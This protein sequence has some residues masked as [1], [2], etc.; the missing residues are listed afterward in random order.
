M[1]S[2]TSSLLNG[3]IMSEELFEDDFRINSKVEDISSKKNLNLTESESG[4]N[5]ALN[6]NRRKSSRPTKPPTHLIES[7]TDPNAVGQT[8]HNLI[9]K[10]SADKPPKQIPRSRNNT[11]PRAAP[12]RMTNVYSDFKCDHCGSRYV[13]NPMRRGNKVSTTKYKVAP[14][15]RIDP[16]TRKILSLCNACG[17]RFNRQKKE[18]PVKDVLSE[19]DIQLIKVQDQDFVQDLSTKLGDP[20]ALRLFCP[21][22]SKTACRCIQKFICG[23]GEELSVEAILE[24]ASMLLEVAIKADE[25]KKLKCYNPDETTKSTKV[26]L[27]NGHRKSQEFEDY[28]LAKRQELRNDIK[29]C[30]KGTQKI[31]SYS[32][33]FLHKRMKT[34]P[35]KGFRIERQKGKAAMGA[36]KEIEILPMESCCVDNC[37]RIALTHGRLLQAWRDR[38]SVSQ[39]EAR[40]VLAEMLTPSG[41]NRANCYRFITWVTGCSSTTIGK[42]N[43]QM[44]LTGGDREPP[45]H[46]LKKYW[47]ENPKKKVEQEQEQEIDMLKDFVPSY[48]ILKAA[49][50]SAGIPKIIEGKTE[51]PIP[52]KRKRVKNTNKSTKKSEVKKLS[53]PTVQTNENIQQTNQN[54]N[55]VIALYGNYQNGGGFITLP[56]GLTPSN[57]ITLPEGVSLQTVQQQLQ[58]QHQLQLQIQLL[59]QQLQHTQAALPQGTLHQTQEGAEYMVTVST[60][61]EVNNL[62]QNTPVVVQAVTTQAMLQNVASQTIVP[63]VVLPTGTTGGISFVSSTPEISILQQQECNDSNNTTS[64]RANMSLL[65]TNLTNNEEI[66]LLTQADARGATLLTQQDVED[67]RRALDSTRL[68]HIVRSQPPSMA[69]SQQPVT[70]SLQTPSITL[71]NLP[72]MLL[73]QHNGNEQQSMI[74]QP[75]SNQ[76]RDRILI[77]SLANQVS[78]QDHV[79]LQR[80]VQ[81]SAQSTNEQGVTITTSILPPMTSFN[82]DVFL[83]SNNTA[84]STYSVFNHDP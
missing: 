51:T 4:N 84:G 81:P 37:V 64:Q 17:L 49:A 50:N 70:I 40:R 77:P 45:E 11:K 79:L 13:V 12:A 25:L 2:D 36:L 5:V 66:N 3:T 82:T 43:D 26:G 59:Q 62:V 23:E 65:A 7:V 73:A 69:I 47:K 74:L 9:K 67:S 80:S 32:N 44:K 71:P 33:N 41:G 20:T 72:T 8:I 56:S 10:T 83:S 57:T 19:E 15:H 42:V 18:K 46:G 52:K 30:E 6:N 24:R 63:T 34:D 28:I 1:I 14:R 35:N 27:G 29:L 53:T 48:E 60:P 76:Q 61:M 38:A 16:E 21:N 58:Q 54:L 75:T 55:T 68:I 22:I 31:L 78:S 39:V